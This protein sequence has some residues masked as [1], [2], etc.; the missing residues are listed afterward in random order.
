V[1]AS[2]FTS[3]LTS[4]IPLCSHFGY[5]AARPQVLSSGC[6]IARAMAL[7]RQA[8]LDDVVQVICGRS[9]ALSMHTRHTLKYV[10]IAHILLFAWGQHAGESP[11]LSVK[12]LRSSVKQ[13]VE[14]LVAEGGGSAE[15]E[16]KLHTAQWMHVSLLPKVLSFFLKAE[17]GENDLEYILG[18]TKPDTS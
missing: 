4:A 16:V 10:D 7:A 3:V 9:L 11:S 18:K 12:S 2:G 15:D 1:F 17:F 5:K 13:F 6:P 14:Q 8:L